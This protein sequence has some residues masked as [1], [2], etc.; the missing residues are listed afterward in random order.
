MTP[1]CL[2]LSCALL[3]A[4]L[5]GIP[6]AQAASTCP[7][8]NTLSTPASDFTINGDG[9]V[10]HI[11]TGLMWKQC[12][13]GLSTT[14]TAC[15]TGSA[16]SGGSATAMNWGAALNAAVA[17][18]A[19]YSDW[20][21][22]NQKELQSI[23]ESGCH[24]P[25]INENA[26]PATP[27]DKAFW[28]STSFTT[29]GSP[30]V[31][32]WSVRFLVGS[33][34][35]APPKSTDNYVRLV[36]SGQPFDSF[37]AKKK[38]QV[39]VFGTAPTLAVGGTGTVSA[40]GGASLNP[41]IFSSLT[42]AVCTVSG[43]TVM[44]GAVGTCTIAANQA[45]NFQYNAAAQVTQSFNVDKANQTIHFGTA[46]TI[47]V[48]GTGVVSA[49][50]SAGFAAIKDSSTP[51]VC[52]ISGNTVTGVTVGTCTIT[53]D[54]HGN[55]NYYAAPQAT[56]SFSIGKGSQTIIF[57]TAPELDV[58]TTNTVNASGGASGNPVT[59][60]SNTLSVCTLSGSTVA[61]VTA[62]TCTLA[63]NQLGNANYFAAPQVTQSFIVGKGSQTIV[64]GPAPTI[65]AGYAGIVS[66]SGGASGNPVT[67]SSTTLSVCTINGSSVT[68]IV[69]GTCT[70][71]ADQLGNLSY[72]P[73]P[74]VTLS[75]V[76]PDPGIRLN[77]TGQADC[78][79][80]TAL[81]A[82]SA[83][84]SGNTAPYPRQDGR[85]GRDAAA[86]AGQLTKLGGG[87]KGFDYTRVCMSGELAGQGAC[88][89][90]PVQ[91]TGANQWACTKDNLTHRIW[92]LESGYGS[93]SSYATSA[94][95]AAMNTSNRCG[96][97]SGW[98][99]PTR[100][101][102][103]SISHHGRTYP[104]IDTD[105]FPGTGASNY[106]ASADTVLS[107]PGNAWVVFFGAGTSGS[108]SKADTFYVR[109]VRSVP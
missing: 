98:R 5:A 29:L 18:F 55:S 107:N 73:A 48:D 3:L 57:V 23:V 74:Q 20:R 6:V 38:A 86:S 99:L 82:C 76:V 9:T 4:I 1:S 51:N 58:G 28:S 79:D 36:R 49:F 94:Y 80:G 11:K 64:F 46:P 45:G 60:S 24:T 40:T 8:N 39:I 59:F 70:I 31:A 65:L 26:F 68:G 87:A 77:D 66:A 54:H 109:L 71:A 72:Y 91:G 12:A 83:A 22:P 41:V 101:E 33:F 27:S 62:G 108:G 97:N 7:A 89:A 25:S 100:R 75:L 90:N 34:S 53:G 10:N 43:S 69:A 14:T 50:T 37:D 106:Y 2:S 42:S 52:T 88:P 85:F 63:A 78:W 56:Q 102:L 35:D 84:N 81:V 61:G 32:A 44:G 15:D 96:F 67:F 105:Y 47:V 93:W 104:A 21:L 92:S 30:L 17:P 95:P 13:E 16:M 103:F 19:G